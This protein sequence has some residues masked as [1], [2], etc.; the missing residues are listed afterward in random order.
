[1]T[2]LIFFFAFLYFLFPNMSFI[3]FPLSKLCSFHCCNRQSQQHLHYYHGYRDNKFHSIFFLSSSSL[4][5][6]FIIW[7]LIFFS[8]MNFPPQ[9]WDWLFD[10]SWLRSP[11]SMEP[12]FRGVKWLWSQPHEVLNVRDRNRER[13]K[14]GMWARITEGKSVVPRPRE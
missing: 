4:F 11:L 14:K 9:I 2:S 7:N 13:G 3:P 6:F 10:A 1:M 8:D 12:C 5:I